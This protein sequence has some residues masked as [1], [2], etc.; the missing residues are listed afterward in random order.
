[1]P[2]FRIAEL[3]VWQANRPPRRLQHGMGVA[4]EVVIQRG[5]ARTRPAIE[6]A[7]GIEAEAIENHQ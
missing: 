5:R 7:A 2:H 6:G 4:G 3:T 1:M